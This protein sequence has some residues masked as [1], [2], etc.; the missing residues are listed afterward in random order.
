M[1]GVSVFLFLL[2]V[3]AEQLL[4]EV[5]AI[6]VGS[7]FRAHAHK[8][9]FNRQA[10]SLETNHALRVPDIHNLHP[11]RKIFHVMTGYI[12]ALLRNGLVGEKVFAVTF[13]CL[14]FGCFFG[15]VLRHNTKFWRNFFLSL[16]GAFMRSHELED[17]F[18]GM[19]YYLLGMAA[20]GCFRRQDGVMGILMLTVGDP[21]A[22][23]CGVLSKR[24]VQKLHMRPP[25]GKTLMGSIGCAAC[26][27]LASY[28]ALR[29]VHF[30]CW[31]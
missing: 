18:S 7:L 26:C 22:G 21:A 29:W 3:V 1:R 4:L 12:F 14:G 24:F 9:R 31:S 20:C 19:A 8:E 23:V 13:A 15:E 2:F 16:F 11:N 25:K 6:H 17:H 30:S 27:A 28:R 5:Q 10:D